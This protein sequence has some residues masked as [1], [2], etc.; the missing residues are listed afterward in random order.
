MEWVYVMT[1]KGWQ[2]N[3]GT[4]PDKNKWHPKTNNNNKDEE[5]IKVSYSANGHTQQIHLLYLFLM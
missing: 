5:N 3:T 2:Y 4:I 1:Q